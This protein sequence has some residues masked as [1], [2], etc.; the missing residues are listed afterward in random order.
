MYYNSNFFKPNNKNTPSIESLVKFINGD[1]SE[2]LQKLN[3]LYFTC[4][5]QETTTLGLAKYFKQL[6]EIIQRFKVEHGIEIETH[7]VIIKFLSGL[8]EKL[9]KV[10]YHKLVAKLKNNNNYSM[11][12]EK[13]VH[14][15]IKENNKINYEMNG[16]EY[17]N[18]TRYF[19]RRFHSINNNQDHKLHFHLM[20]VEWNCDEQLSNEEL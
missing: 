18:N 10:V 2:E 19:E 15:A 1:G 4:V 14:I 3:N 8:T 12:L 9:I 6:Q 16:M 5:L 17:Q 11:S 20:C 13:I 7:Q